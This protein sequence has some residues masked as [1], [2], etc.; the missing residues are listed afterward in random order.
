MKD[1]NLPIG[2][3]FDAIKKD[4]KIRT[5]SEL[6]AKLGVHK[7]VI[8]KTR[9]GRLNVGP[10]MILRMHEAFGIPVETIRKDLEE[11]EAP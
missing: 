4:Y 11:V 3:M 5:D 6:A 1:N 8:A 7:P 2:R 10:N 9:A